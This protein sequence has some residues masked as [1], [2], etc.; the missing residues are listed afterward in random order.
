MREFHFYSLLVSI[1]LVG[2]LSLEVLAEDIYIKG[3]RIEAME[4][5]VIIELS[6]PIRNG[7]M[8]E[9]SEPCLTKAVVELKKALPAISRFY[10]EA[11]DYP[12]DKEK[13]MLLQIVE[14]KNTNPRI[15]PLF[16]ADLVGYAVIRV[17][18]QVVINLEDFHCG[19][20]SQE[21]II[22]KLQT[23]TKKVREKLNPRPKEKKELGPRGQ[24]LVDHLDRILNP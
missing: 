13:V 12:K 20:L 23:A 22:G 16:L 18:A 1:F 5:G 7:A 14:S 15:A 6:A 2:A 8:K 9:T 21:E 4:E 3:A 24:D 10:D 17:A 19:Y 11:P